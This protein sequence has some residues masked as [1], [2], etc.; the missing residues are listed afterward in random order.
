MNLTS[1]ESPLQTHERARKGED[2]RTGCFSPVL[3]TQAH[4]EGDEFSLEFA[5]IHRQAD[6]TGQH[7]DDHPGT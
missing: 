7:R 5:I 4:G 6:G 2:F 1:A 3:L